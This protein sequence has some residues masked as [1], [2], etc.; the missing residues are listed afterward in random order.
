LISGAVIEA[1]EGVTALGF[2]LYIAI[3]ALVGKPH[4]MAGAVAVAVLLIGAGAA[5][6]AVAR[7]LLR[8]M[9]WARSPAVLTQ[10]F[11]I[12][13]AYNL[14]QSKQTIFA[15]ALAGCAAVALIMLFAP[16]TTRALTQDDDAE[17]RG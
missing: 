15:V 13:I 5:M 9:S 4:D 12:F 11:A 2:G 14:Y 6:L 16:G 7:G 17:D 1:L 10:L 8:R 3:E